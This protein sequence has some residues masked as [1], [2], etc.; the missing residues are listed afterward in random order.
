VCDGTISGSVVYAGRAKATIALVGSKCTNGKI[1]AKFE[2]TPPFS[3]TWSDD[4][5]DF[6]T[7]NYAIEHTPV[8]GKWINFLYFIGNFHDANC[9]D[10]NAYDDSN[11]LTMND[12]PY[13]SKR[14]GAFGGSFMVSRTRRSASKSTA[15]SPPA[16]RRIARRSSPPTWRAIRRFT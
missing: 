11:L 2:G 6:T 7:N 12:P 10:P 3:G 4:L 1:V 16:P 5:T 14:I 13:S 9:S 15:A 8:P